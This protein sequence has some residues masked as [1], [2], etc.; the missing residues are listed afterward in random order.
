MKNLQFIIPVLIICN[1]K[2]QLNCNFAL[3]LAYCLSNCKYSHSC[4]S[5]DNNCISE[6]KNLTQF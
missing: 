2:S 5:Y 1:M 3:N 6:I 4:S